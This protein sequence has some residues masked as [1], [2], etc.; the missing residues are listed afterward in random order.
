MNKNWMTEQFFRMWPRAL[1]HVKEGRA[2][3]E[4]HLSSPGVYVLYRNDTPYYIGKT[5]RPLIKRLSQHALKPNALRYNFWNYFSAFQ[6]GDKDDRDEI[7]AILIS[8]MPTA[9]SSHPK[10]S[11]RKLDRAVSKL[12]NDIQAQMLTGRPDRSGISNPESI[13]EED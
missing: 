9:N 8:A 5:S 3:L 7:E 1:F 13:E 6:V 12:L 2:F 10:F 4:Q 11:R